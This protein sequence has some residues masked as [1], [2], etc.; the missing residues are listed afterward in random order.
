[1]SKPAS[2]APAKAPALLSAVASHEEQLMDSLRQA[3]A[4]AR[5]A[6]DSAHADAAANL[7]E[8]SAQLDVEMAEMRRKAAQEREAEVQRV[9][10]ASL[11]RVAGIRANAD[12]KLA[13]VRSEIL[14]RILPTS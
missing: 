10:A 7:T 5:A 12:A 4:Q 1:M 8:T 6:V 9:Q 11:D 14:R 3:Q 13:A 2:A